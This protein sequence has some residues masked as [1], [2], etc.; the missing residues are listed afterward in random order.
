MKNLIPIVVILSWLLSCSSGQKTTIDD[1]PVNGQDL[2]NVFKPLDG[3]WEGV[4]YVYS[5]EN[6]QKNGKAQPKDIQL[7]ALSDLSLKTELEINVTQVYVSDNPYFQTVQIT[8]RYADGRVVKSAGY[9]KVEDGKMLC[10]VNKPDEQVIHDG[11]TDGDDTIIWQR[12]ELNPLKIEFFRETV[13]TDSYTI[14]GWGYY[15]ND[16]P[17]LTPRTWFLGDY[18]RVN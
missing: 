12:S 17:K 5:D 2:V 1:K 9:N 18:K 7:E 10:V 14:V 13:T 16:D 11:S 4:F 15:G 8:D 6:G 3:T